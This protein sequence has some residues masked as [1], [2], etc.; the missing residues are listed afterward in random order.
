MEPTAGRWEE[1]G[2]PGRKI[3]REAQG[4]MHVEETRH[5]RMS[6]APKEDNTSKKEEIV[7]CPGCHR[8]ATR[9]MVEAHA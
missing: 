6:Q 3:E 5:S 9:E 7:P 1:E 8:E 4:A 2:K